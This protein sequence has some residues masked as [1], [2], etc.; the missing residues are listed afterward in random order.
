MGNVPGPAGGRGG[1]EHDRGGGSEGVRCSGWPHCR[2]AHAAL[3]RQLARNHA[4]LFS[5]LVAK[6]FCKQGC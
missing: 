4:A 6:Q 1:G 5:S 2:L 3:P